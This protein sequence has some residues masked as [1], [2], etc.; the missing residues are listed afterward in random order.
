MVRRYGECVWDDRRAA[1]LRYMLESAV[2]RRFPQVR[3][4]REFS[5]PTGQ[6]RLQ[7]RCLGPWPHNAEF[8][9]CLAKRSRLCSPRLHLAWHRRGRPSLASPGL[10]LARTTTASELSPS[11]AFHDLSL[12]SSGMCVLL[13]VP[14]AGHQGVRAEPRPVGTGGAVL[15]SQQRRLLDHAVRTRAAALSM[16][17]WEAHTCAAKEKGG[18]GRGVA[19]F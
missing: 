15:R 13:D 7:P 4:R 3:A 10:A 1:K 8:R 11:C 18:K 16:C 9:P 2:Q 6:A 17:L 19:L 14:L 5:G 12:Y